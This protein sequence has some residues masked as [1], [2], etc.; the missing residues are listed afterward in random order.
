[1]GA[2]EQIASSGILPTLAQILRQKGS[3]TSQVTLLVAEMAREGN[4]NILQHSLLLINNIF[5]LWL[6]VQ[7]TVIYTALEKL[8][9]HC[10]FSFSLVLLFLEKKLFYSINY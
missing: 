4:R 10:K 1:M 3:F 5:H 9:D 2:A 7:V 8:R 6:A